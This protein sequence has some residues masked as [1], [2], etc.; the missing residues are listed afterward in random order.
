MHENTA[1]SNRKE[2]RFWCT[3]D[4]FVHDNRS[5]RHHTTSTPL[6]SS[7]SFFS[8]GT[9][10]CLPMIKDWKLRR[11]VSWKGVTMASPPHAASSLSAGTNSQTASTASS[12]KIPSPTSSSATAAKS[13]AQKTKSSPKAKTSGNSSQKANAPARSDPH[14]PH[15]GVSIPRTRSTSFV[16]KEPY[17]SSG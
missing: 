16:P 14:P 12:T 15:S 9:P 13:P 11:T 5:P 2:G 7:V 17:E 8:V 6:S 3:D 10:A 1:C 4:G